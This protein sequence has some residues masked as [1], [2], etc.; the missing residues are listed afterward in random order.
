MPTT[1]I[2]LIFAA[3]LIALAIAAF[4]YFY[5]RKGN[6]LQNAVFT[7]LRFLTL[8]SVLLLL[9]NPK[10]RKVEYF[11]EKPELVLAVDNSA[12]ISNLGENQQVKDFI[13]EISQDPELR[14]RFKI[15]IFTFGDGVS[16]TSQ[17][18]FEDKQTNISEALNELNRLYEN[19]T[20]PTI[21]ISDG[22]QTIGEE[23]TFSARRYEQPLFPVVIGDT[24]VF[25]DLAVSRVNV[26][27]YTFLDN[28][29]PV[30]TM[31]TYS[32]KG[33]ADTRVDIRYGNRVVFSK[34]ISL[35]ES[36]NSKVLQ[37]ELPASSVG[38]HT[39][40]VRVVPLS[41][42]KN[43]INN[44]KE[45]AIEVIDERTRVLIAYDL[46]H[47]DLG[48]LKKAIE[49]NR[50]R[51]VKLQQVNP[52]VDLEEYQLVILFQPINSFKVLFD[53]LHEKKK[54][55]WVITGPKTDW[56]FLNSQQDIFS[57]E[58]TQ[59]TEEF[60][61]LFNENFSAFQF[62]DIGFSQF[63]PLQGNFGQ[64]TSYAENESLLFRKIQGIETQNPLLSI[65]EEKNWKRA[66]LFGS[67][68]WKW[69]S[70]VYQKSTSFEAF[71]GFIGKLVQFLSSGKSKQRLS[72]SYEPLYRGS[73][74]LII[75]AEYFDKNY[76]FD[77]NAN[78]SIRLKNVETQEVQQMPF[79]L[80]R[81]SYSVDL[82]NLKRG[83]YG[84]MVTVAGENLSRSGKFKS[85]S[86]D[87]EKQF[88]GANYRALQK[89]AE[90]KGQQVYFLNE[91]GKLKT[92]LLSSKTL[93]PIQKS[94]ENNVPLIEWYYLLGIIVLSLSIEWFLRKYYG[95][96]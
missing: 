92:R 69:R 51:E 10:L 53:Q 33:V 1:T 56:S 79:L 52:P 85:L 38:V 64:I 20:A 39:Y 36:D 44:T 96:I 70:Q 78:I 91:A 35:S 18:S 30:E 93:L 65:S 34:N 6:R 58:I 57:Q 86:F 14:K 80:A 32:G 13:S 28:R 47:P 37:T 41:E 62:D 89:V 43:V 11:T 55:Y 63:P 46:M 82:S 90:E 29:F 9:I 22:N 75:T 7:F 87:V 50:Q 60:L 95:Y 31:I 54:N 67:D 68:I 15:D 40:S 5:K 45:F 19:S 25:T 48:A 27:K 59:Q 8:F 71:D 21:L 12:S 49:S 73:E 84:F 81:N 4:Q 61:P 3:L 88:F 94:H 23:F 2:L 83:E 77:P 17:F 66:F 42:E 72:V 26:N 76:V 74:K 24:T 16:K